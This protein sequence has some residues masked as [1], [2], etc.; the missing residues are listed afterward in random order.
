MIINWWIPN[1]QH[2]HCEDECGSDM[3]SCISGERVKHSASLCCH[4]WLGLHIASIDHSYRWF[5]KATDTQKLQF[6]R[7]VDLFLTLLSALHFSQLVC[8]TCWS[9]WKCERMGSR[10]KRTRMK[11]PDQLHRDDKHPNICHLVSTCHHLLE[12]LSALLS[13]CPLADFRPTPFIPE[14]VFLTALTINDK[15]E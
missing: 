1:D 5:N 11:V 12:G 14:Q 3:I 7:M 4:Q 6:K 8:I 15:W 9:I 10:D 13:V 2:G